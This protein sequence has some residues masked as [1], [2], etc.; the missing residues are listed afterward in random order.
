M[1]EPCILLVERDTRT[2]ELL[3]AILRRFNPRLRVLTT[4]S[5]EKAID[6]LAANPVHLM[7][8]DCQGAKRDNRWLRE[9]VRQTRRLEG[10]PILF[11]S[12]ES[13][14][15][16]ELADHEFQLPKPF[17][18]LALVGKID[19]ILVSDDSSASGMLRSGAQTRP[20]IAP[21][22]EPPP[23]TIIRTKFAEVMEGV[24]VRIT[25]MTPQPVP[26][27]LIKRHLLFSR[28][29]QTYRMQ[30]H[31]RKSGDEVLFNVVPS[32]AMPG[33][34]E[35][36]FEVIVKHPK[37]GAERRSPPMPEFLLAR[38]KEEVT[39]EGEIDRVS[40]FVAARYLTGDVPAGSGTL[41]HEFVVNRVAFP[42]GT[43]PGATADL[44][45]SVGVRPNPVKTLAEY[46]ARV[47]ERVRQWGSKG[48][49]D[50]KKTLIEAVLGLEDLATR[51]P[52]ARDRIGKAA[53][54]LSA[55]TLVLQDHWSS[56][57]RAGSCEK[58]RWAANDPR[59]TGLSGVSGE[60]V[61][62]DPI[63]RIVFD[64]SHWFELLDAHGSSAGD[65]AFKVEGV[66]VSAA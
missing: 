23:T 61:F 13:E 47:N 7:A 50:V 17:S 49:A 45:V 28:A 59:I 25:Q 51:T 46:W 31:F 12:R 35:L 53:L 30:E 2:L 1:A 18:A 24:K 55:L 41:G 11:L 33:Y 57:Y 66:Q 64:E 29:I 10:L 27:D 20:P 22:N 21:G 5:A 3:H 52:E 8:C 37:G 44:T 48:A 65:R 15:P 58:V 56:R 60:V 38:S 63:G 62:D 54:Y 4:D 32:E 34:N 19:E 39:V 42:A 36:R 43:K 9:Q 16:A 26:D 6:L 40:R 14:V